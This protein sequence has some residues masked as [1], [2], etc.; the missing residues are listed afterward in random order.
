MVTEAHIYH[1]YDSESLNDLRGSE[2]N[3]SVFWKYFG[4]TSYPHSPQTRL[5]NNIFEFLNG[6]LE[7]DRQRSDKVTSSISSCVQRVERGSDSADTV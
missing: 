2:M 1:C 3:L 7:L 6:P 4:R 5:M